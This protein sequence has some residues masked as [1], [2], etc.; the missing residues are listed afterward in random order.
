MNTSIRFKGVTKNF[1]G[2]RALD[3]VSFL[4]ER[5]TVHAICG[6]N[7][8]G[9]STL[10]KILA[11]IEQPDAGSIELDGKRLSLESP[12]DAL[13]AGIAMVHQELAFCDNLSVA[14]NLSLGRLSPP[15]RRAAR[16]PS[17]FSVP[18]A[19]RSIPTAGCAR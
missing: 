3:G 13:E 17:S 2:V 6:E 9:K 10:G 4:V 8:A 14:E 11:G 12:R 7:G 18:S 15:A 5:G 16:G 1:A 19:R